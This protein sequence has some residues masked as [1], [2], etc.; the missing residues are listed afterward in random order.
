MKYSN[1]PPN[2]SFDVEVTE[3]IRN[4]TTLQMF[5]LVANPLR[6]GFMSQAPSF[7]S[8]ST[9]IITE[10]MMARVKNDQSA[11]MEQR[12]MRQKCIAVR[13]ESCRQCIRTRMQS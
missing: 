4:G 7:E 3:A 13:T 1:P 6:G 8:E 10:N 11:K 2:T 5:E 12:K 9:A